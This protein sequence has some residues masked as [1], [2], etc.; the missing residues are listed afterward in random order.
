MIE[1]TMLIFSIMMINGPRGTHVT[2]YNLRLIVIQN[3]IYIVYLID[4][5]KNS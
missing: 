5:A 4:H 1:R 3:R 2:D